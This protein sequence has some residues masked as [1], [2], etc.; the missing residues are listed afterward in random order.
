MIESKEDFVFSITKFESGS[1]FNVLP[2]DAIIFGTIR[3]Y[4]PKVLEKVKEKMIHIATCTANAFDCKVEFEINDKYPVTINPKTETE[5][6][7]RIA[8]KYFGAERV[9]SLDLPMTGSE[10]FSYYLMSRPG[11][12]YAI[13][14]KN[15]DHKYVLHSSCMDYND[16]MIGTGAYMFVRVVEDR[17]DVKIL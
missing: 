4:N 7:F 10:D 13:G 16:S 6:I 17:L 9:S 5:H 2:D 8:K 14:T 1:A 12:F 3:T 11:C 15:P